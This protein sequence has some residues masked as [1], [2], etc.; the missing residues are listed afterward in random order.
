MRTERRVVLMTGNQRRHRWVAATLARET[1]LV[2]IVSEAKLPVVRKPE[3]LPASDLETIE[4]HLAERD[5]VERRLLGEIEYFPDTAV[6]ALPRG[7]TNSPETFEW[8]RRLAPEVI[9]LY[10]TGIIRP[11]LLDHYADNMINV[12]LGLSPYYRG[13]G[14]NFWPLVYREPECVG[15]TIHLAVQDVDAG[16]ILAQVRPD[17]VV[18]DRA[19]ELGTRTIMAAF[20]RLPEIVE[21]Y[22]AGEIQPQAQDL[23][24]GRVFKRK[25]FNADAVRTMWRNFDDGMMAAYLSDVEG[26]RAQFPIIDPA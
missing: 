7:E 22:I 19:H 26:R 21:R 2:G 11:P 25:D 17:V 18:T 15:A 13:S 5:E 1:N 12:H 10:G 6:R 4:R 16:G 9:V 8:V 20:I 14:T 24:L 23:S 3:A